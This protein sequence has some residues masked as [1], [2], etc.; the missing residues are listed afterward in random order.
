MKKV[1]KQLATVQ[2]KLVTLSKQQLKKQLA[3]ASKSLVNLSKQLEKLSI[4]VD[5]LQAAEATAKKKPVAKKK[6]AVRK[7]AGV[8]KPTAVKGETVLGSVFDSI[9]RSKKGI[10]IEKIKEKTGY[11]G[12]QLSNA[13]YK[14]TKQSKIKTVSRGVYIKK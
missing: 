5:K 8:K 3:T 1:K 13:L 12:R 10:A 11:D 6:P 2:K 7:K 14:L 4:H 9:K